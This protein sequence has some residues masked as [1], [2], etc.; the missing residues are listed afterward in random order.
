MTASKPRVKVEI[1]ERS[2]STPD[3]K[4]WAGVIETARGAVYFCSWTRDEPPT[5]AEVIETW[6]TDRRAFLPGYGG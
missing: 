6:K 4:V 1:R 5:E 3:R 2:M